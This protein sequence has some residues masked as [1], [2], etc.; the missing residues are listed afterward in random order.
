MYTKFRALFFTFRAIFSVEPKAARPKPRNVEGPRAPNQR[1]EGNQGD[2]G[3][4]GPK[5]NKKGANPFNQGTLQ[6][7]GG[8][9]KQNE[10]IRF[11]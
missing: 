1:M 2:V 7:E 3:Q 5:A 8:R 4:Q 6:E 10:A 9:S 11:F